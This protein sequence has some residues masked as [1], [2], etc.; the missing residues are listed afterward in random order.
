[1]GTYIGK[2]IVPVHCGRWEKNRSYEMLSIVLNTENGDSYIARRD[3]PAG[4]VLT[5]ESYWMLHSLFSQQI[6]DMADELA[7]AEKRIKAD[8]DETEAAI[9]ADNDSTEQTILAD[10]AQTR[11]HVDTSLAETTKTLTETVTSARDAMTEQKKS[12]DS[13]AEQLNA[14]MDSVLAAGTGA[15]DTEILDARVDVDGT[16]HD[17]LG[18]HIR[19]ILPEAERRADRIFHERMGEEYAPAIMEKMATDLHEGTLRYT[20]SS[21]SFSGWVSQYEM[22]EAMVVTGASFYVKARDTAVNEIRFSIA[23]DS[24][25]DASK[26]YE[27]TLSVNIEPET[28]QLVSCQIPSIRLEKGRVV[29]ICVECDAICSQGFGSKNDED[30]VS[31]YST[32]G[33][34][35]PLEKYAYGSTV[36]LYMHFTG[37]SAAAFRTDL[38]EARMDEAETGISGLEESARE[39]KK[40]YDTFGWE[41]VLEN[42]QDKLPVTSATLQYNTSTF[43]GW[44]T[45]VGVL[46]TFDTAVFSVRNRSEEQ[47]LEKIRCVILKED[48][49]GEILADETQDGFHIAPGETKEI[50]FHF[51]EP[52]SNEAGDKLYFAFECD[53]LVAIYGGDSGVNLNAPDYGN[54]IYRANSGTP[55]FAVG[56]AMS[57]WQNLYDTDKKNQ[58]KMDVHF[59]LMAAHYRLGED[60]QSQVKGIYEGLGLTEKQ[61]TA[62]KELIGE[63]AL[64]DAQEAEVSDLIQ[65]RISTSGAPRVILPDVFH[66]VAG[67]TLQL[68]YRG[69]IEH[70]YPYFYNIEFRCDI[71]KNTSRYFEVTP[72][73]AQAGDHKLT[74]RVRDHLDNILASAETV[75]RV[76]TVGSGPEAQK[77]ILCVGDS[78]TSSGAWCKEAMRRLSEAGGEPEGLELPNIRFIGT[79]RN[80]DCGY[81]G[82]GG[83]TWASYLAEP[84]P[85]TLGM[86]VYGSH[87]KDSGDQHSIWKDGNGNLWS[88]ETVEEGRI[89]FTRYQNHTGA[90]PLGEGTL[91]HYQNASH[92]ADTVFEETVYAEGNPFWDADE[93]Q[94]NFKT[95]CERNGFGQVDYLYTLLSWNALGGNYSEPDSAAVS[96]HAKNARTL[97][98]ILHS[99]YP[100]AKVKVMGIQMPS[101]DGGTGQNYGANSGYSNWYGLVR[102]VMGMNLAYQEL[103]NE[104]EFKGYVEF[105]NIS[106][107][108]DSEYNM[109]SQSKPVNTRSTSTER[110]GTNGVHP[111]TAGYLQIGDAAFRSMVGELAGD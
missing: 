100:D 57:R 30:R 17:T 18:A 11:E 40:L 69:L 47:Y 38:L 72:T 13:T 4:T 81:E 101:L 6:R 63:A 54:V 78:L 73:E 83:W 104:E 32:N 3:V 61:D 26:V 56:E 21:S 110:V 48:R 16:A 39:F 60:M 85:T 80:G 75:L 93:G 107:Q 66:A 86:W 7:A 62:V 23:L 53:Q 92:T 58:T 64:N 33:A 29:F 102:S 51:T 88:M 49:Y 90:M 71:G 67:D 46:E 20:Y 68:F 19:S 41:E 1:M 87:D 70:P 98:R 44:G 77:N 74:V 10:N 108:F 111:S 94:V 52:V 103:A 97:I 8:N 35:I 34:H 89:K 109:P 43:T 25:E 27:V 95:Y 42:I 105:I 9:K 76:H 15:G 79:K 37:Y 91:T 31:W 14:R 5:D 50:T 82:Y 84:K 65:E 2:R 45:P 59:G 106:G 28:E 12:F 24:R 96:A 55:P 99:Q 36:R 22:P